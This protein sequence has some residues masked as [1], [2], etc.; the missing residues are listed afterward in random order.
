MSDVSAVPSGY[1][2]RTELVGKGRMVIVAMLLPLAMLFSV[3]ACDDFDFFAVLDGSE[4]DGSETDD[5]P[6]GALAISPVSVTIPARG[7]LTFSAL[8]GVPP[9]TYAVVSGTG[10]I[11]EASGNYTASDS[12]G[13]D[14]VR[15]TDGVGDTSDASVITV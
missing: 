13:A 6:S 4:D 11:D 10:T 9:Y 3:T 2:Y 15:V 8:G 7:Q 1:R 12:P 5:T 14:L